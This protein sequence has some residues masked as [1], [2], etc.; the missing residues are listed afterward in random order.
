MLTFSENLTQYPVKYI[1]ML[2]LVAKENS[3]YITL[4]GKGRPKLCVTGTCVR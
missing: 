2:G 4:E 3:N 1:K